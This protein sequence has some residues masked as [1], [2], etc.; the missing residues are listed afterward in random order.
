MGNIS[1]LGEIIKQ[2]DMLSS[3]SVEIVPNTTAD[4]QSK[5]SEL[6]MSNG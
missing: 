4:D 2:L 6:M 5:V 1:K 3:Y